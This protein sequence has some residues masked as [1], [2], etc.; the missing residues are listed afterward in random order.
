MTTERPEWRACRIRAEDEQ[1]P[2]PA[3]I[4]NPEPLTTDQVDEIKTR[5]ATAAGQPSIVTA[6]TRWIH[7][8][9]VG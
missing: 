8:D 5:F 6:D 3:L 4:V 2:L 1:P 7:V 9:R